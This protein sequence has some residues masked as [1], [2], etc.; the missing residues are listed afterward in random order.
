[1]IQR[2]LTA[3]VFLFLLFQDRPESVQ[4]PVRL[5]AAGGAGHPQR[6]ALH[7]RRHQLR[8]EGEAGAHAG[9]NTRK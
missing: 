3:T 5:Q 9:K 7:P 2:S 8:G 1:M 6:G 4:Q